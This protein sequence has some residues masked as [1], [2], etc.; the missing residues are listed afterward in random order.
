[1]KTIKPNLHNGTA[2]NLSDAPDNLFLELQERAEPD[3][4][5]VFPSKRRWEHVQQK[6]ERFQQ[7]GKEWDWNNKELHGNLLREFQR[8]CKRAGIISSPSIA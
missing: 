1:V 4:P 2:N 3:C 8:T 6:W 5:F 7:E